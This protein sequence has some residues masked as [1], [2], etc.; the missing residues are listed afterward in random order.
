ML[1]QWYN[2]SEPR[3]EET[4]G[5]RISF[6]RFVGLGLQDDTPDYSIVSRF[7]AELE[8]R[9]LSESLFK[10]LETQLDEMGLILKEGTLMEATLVEA[11]VRRPAASAGLGAKSRTDPDADWTRSGRERRSHFGY[12]VHLGVEAGTGLV[13]RA[14][15]TLAKVYESEVAETW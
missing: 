10:E 4:L 13:R 9:G 7:G 14:A 11:Q 12:K 1:E 5:D 2:L 3:M 6:R 15:L 8:K